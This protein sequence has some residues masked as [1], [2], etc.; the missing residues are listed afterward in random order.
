[1]LKFSS[2]AAT[3]TMTGD[4]DSLHFNPDKPISRQM[5]A[6][7]AARVIDRSRAAGILIKDV[8]EN[9]PFSAYI[10]SMVGFNIMDLDRDFSFRPATALTIEELSTMVRVASFACLPGLWCI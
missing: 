5:A 1:M 9:H 7:I 4:T 3:G 10:N 6:K 8:D 2:L